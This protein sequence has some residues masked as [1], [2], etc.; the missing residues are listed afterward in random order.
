MEVVWVEAA[1]R[2]GTAHPL[3]EGFAGRVALGLYHGDAF[4]QQGK[5]EVRAAGRGGDVAD[6]PPHQA[7]EGADARQHDPLLPHLALDRG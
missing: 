3:H 6:G 7:G 5:G 4:G 2:D 1:C